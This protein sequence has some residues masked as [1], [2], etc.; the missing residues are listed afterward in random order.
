MWIFKKWPPGKRTK[1]RTRTDPKQPKDPPTFSENIFINDKRLGKYLYGAKLTTETESSTVVEVWCL[2][3]THRKMK[4]RSGLVKTWTYRC[5]SCWIS[6]IMQQQVKRNA[7]SDFKEARWFQGDES[8]CR[9]VLLTGD[10]VYLF[11]FSLN[12]NKKIIW[13]LK[14]WVTL[15]GFWAIRG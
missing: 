5:F 14:F 15:T 11:V 10:L 12:K 9:L 7:L 3:K 4:F 13:K 6:S 8:Y 2:K 1:T